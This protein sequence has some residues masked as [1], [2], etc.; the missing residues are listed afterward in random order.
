[1][2]V[3]TARQSWMILVIYL[4]EQSD[5]YSSNSAV[6]DSISDCCASQDAAF[7]SVNISNTHLSALQPY[8]PLGHPSTIVRDLARV[9]TSSILGDVD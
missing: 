5:T 6:Q 3:I 2:E 7:G 4:M 8:C 1:M 9:H